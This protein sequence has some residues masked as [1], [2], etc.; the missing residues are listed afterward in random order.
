[1]L[2]PAC[3]SSQSGHRSLIWN[4]FGSRGAVYGAFDHGGESVS[5]IVSPSGP[6]RGWGQCRSSEPGQ[7]PS[8]MRES[9][10]PA[11]RAGRE[12]GQSWEKSQRQAWSGSTI[13]A[14]GSR[15][16]GALD[17]Q[18]DRQR[19]CRP[20]ETR[21]AATLAG[22]MESGRSRYPDR[23]WRLLPKGVVER[24]AV[25]AKQRGEVAAPQS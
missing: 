18:P 6:L 1:M 24:R 10:R 7:D 8:R 20:A 21:A 2:E 9:G 25:R 17:G 4:G 11:R 5:S 22:N 15:G 3:P 23:C 13:P 19:S 12:I 14:A 16:L